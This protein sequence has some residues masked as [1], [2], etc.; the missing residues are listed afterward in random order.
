MP[1]Y[2]LKLIEN[3]F[4]RVFY[5]I[6]IRNLHYLNSP[7]PTI[8]SPN[9]SNAFIDPTILGMLPR[10]KVRFF[11]RGDVF[12]G[13]FMRWLLEGLNISPMFR[14]QEGGF[15]EVRKNDKTF[16]ECKRLL[17]EDKNI[18]LFPEAVCVQERRIRRLRKGLSRIAFMT[19]E[20]FDFKKDL[21]VVPVG[22]NYS[23][24][25]RM[26][27]S[28]FID[29]GKPF[30]LKEFGLRYKEDKVKAINEF[31]T[32]LQ[33]RMEE[34]VVV[35]ENPAH[36]ELVKAIEQVYLRQ[37]MKEEKIK[38]NDL[39]GQ[40][41]ISKKIAG[42]VNSCDKKDPAL[43][44]ELKSR[45][46]PYTAS[47]HRLRLRDHLLA[48]DAIHGMN[49]W[50]FFRDFLVIWFGMPLYCLGVFMN[51]PPY[52]LA[53]RVAD[54][55]VKQVEF[56]ASVHANLAWILWFPWYGI[57]LLAVALIFRS[58]ALLGAYALAVPLLLAFVISYYP[59]MKKIFGRWRLLR[60]VRKKRAEVEKLLYQREE[61]ISMLDELKSGYA[62]N[63]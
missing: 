30:S 28:V 61:I 15:N 12:K 54:K 5:R 45:I 32:F 46:L 8:I 25:S 53:K 9:H 50:T 14:M 11:A 38:K 47:L 57:Q 3:I 55:K 42:M 4:Y 34:L 13:R 29:I 44:A 35:I 17:S 2:I 27:S 40:T 7:K 10:K 56:Y 21:L 49:M 51:Y 22:L 60:Y 20:A 43:L 19:E 37:W 16:E 39:A 6:Q 24:P 1:Y 18:M 41:A 33:Q 36:D 58:W 59:G 26:G 48:K 63:P 62:A 52:F 23:D 31:T